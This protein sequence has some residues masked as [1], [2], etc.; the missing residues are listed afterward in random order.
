MKVL[1]I[2][3]GKYQHVGYPIGSIADVPENI[4]KGWIASKMSKKIPKKKAE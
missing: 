2:K 3:K 1:M 4:A